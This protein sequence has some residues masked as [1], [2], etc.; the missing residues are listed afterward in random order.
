MKSSRKRFLEVWVFSSF[1][2]IALALILFA[3]NIIAG[4]MHKRLD[5]TSD[6]VYTLSE[7]TREILKSL[8]TPVTIQ[9]FFSKD[10]PQMPMD[11][12]NYAQRV[13]DFLKEYQAASGGK[14]RIQRLNPTPDSDAEDAA[15]LAGIYG[16]AVDLSGERIYFGIAVTC[17]DQTV[18]IPFLSPAREPFLEYDIT[19]AIYR[20][21]HPEKPVI[22]VMSSLPVMGS[23]MP[24]VMG[25]PQQHKPWLLISELKR[26][27]DVRK[28]D[29]SADEIDKDINV[30]LVVHPRNLSDK[31]L[32]AIDQFVLRGGRLIA[33]LDPMNVV[34]RQTNPMSQFQFTPPGASTLG[35][36]LDKWGIE[37]NTDKVVADMVYMTRVQGR[38]GRPESMPTILSL[39]KQALLENDPAIGRLSSL[40]FAF[41]GAFEGSPADGLKQDVL[42]KTSDQCQL[43][44][45]FMAQM[46]GNAIIRDFKPEN[47]PM[48][49]AIRLTGE[50]KTAFPD[51]KPGSE[52]KDKDA[53]SNDKNDGKDSKTESKDKAKEKDKEKTES[54]KTGKSTVILVADA[55]M[56]YD[57]F[58]VQR[59]RLFG[60][61]VI[62]PLNENLSFAQNLIDYLSGD[63]R[64]LSIRG[65][66]VK[67]RP[68]LVVRR[69]Q[70]EAR[71]QWQDQIRALEDKLS[72]TKSKIEELERK[73]DKSQRLALT[74][75]QQEA[76]RKFRKEEAETRKR[77]KELRKKLRRDI[78]RL[79]RNLELF[80][81]AFMPCVVGLG[82]ILIAFTKR[83]KSV[84]K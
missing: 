74:P 62:V 57:N 13:E 37:F 31:T 61:E 10:V 60:Q 35:K 17:L 50:F 48:A 15:H 32:Y 28:I 70:A 69:M 55:D 64:L 46:P 75:E 38:D 84:H 80:N 26:D 44:E 29:T 14:V 53:D 6:K 27:F 12:R 76:I 68:F 5:L 59:R 21:L 33:F 78:D 54:L 56:L 81:M 77:L 41:S 11:L 43:V 63:R 40:L 25:R 2:L 71:R 9:F 34:E 16:Q 20:V 51:G 49:L 58:C 65:R 23:N 66:G 24:P 7:G 45:K 47:K 52:E 36:L 79:Q 8:D 39:P 19:R 22:G 3:V 30:L 73:K 1:G 72:E 67:H 18:A 4:A 82:G 83:R 42:V